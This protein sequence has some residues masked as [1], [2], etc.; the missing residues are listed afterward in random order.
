[1]Q[2]FLLCSPMPPFGLWDQRSSSTG[3]G[4]LLL[5][6][7]RLVASSPESSQC[8]PCRSAH[9][10][11]SQGLK[12]QLRLSAETGRRHNGDTSQAICILGS[13]LMRGKP[14]P[15][16]GTSA[17]RRYVGQTPSLMLVVS[18][19]PTP[20]FLRKQE[21]RFPWKQREEKKRDPSFRWDDGSEK[22][23]CI[24]DSPSKGRGIALEERGGGV[25]PVTPLRQASSAT[26]PARGGL[27]P[28][29]DYPCV[30]A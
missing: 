11:P 27:R 14:A 26:S 19:Q 30:T 5:L 16:S 8:M 7:S 22:A 6:W 2:P 1:M 10:T 9:F 28:Q 21:S 13:A 4:K 20:S 17:N 25:S 3:P 29:S 15:R 23:Q 18:R 12:G 24:N